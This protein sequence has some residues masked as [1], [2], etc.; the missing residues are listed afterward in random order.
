MD[1]GAPPG[2]VRLPG[3]AMPV[4][5]SV[6]GPRGA[7]A[8][9]TVLAMPTMSVP[10]PPSSLTWRTLGL[11]RHPAR[12]ADPCGGGD[13]EMAPLVKVA[14]AGADGPLRVGRCEVWRIRVAAAWARAETHRALLD[15]AERAREAQ[16]EHGVDRARFVVARAAVRR[17]VGLQLGVPGERL[18]LTTG[19]HGKPML[20]DPFARLHFNVSH[21]GDWVLVALDATAP[22][23]VDVEQV[24]PE[25]DR[26]DDYAAVLSPEEHA[27][28]R[29]LPAGT[30]A[31]AMARLWVRKEAYV[32]ALGEGLNRPLHD[33]CIGDDG[34]GRPQV[35]YDRHG[36]GPGAPW[37]LTDLPVDGRHVAC[38]AWR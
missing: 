27:A 6:P 32:K 38:V 13:R 35:H 8:A 10:Q 22:V 4:G 24:R 15:D 23:G 31:Q 11:R 16:F 33:I 3:R 21:A 7:V 26:I 17:L 9:P 19:A 14:S 1:D 18:A 29:V 25:L 28:L 34:C 5:A 30:R 2:A 12:P 36:S 37:Q 20:A